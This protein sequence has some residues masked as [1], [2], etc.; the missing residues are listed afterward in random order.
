[1]NMLRA[2][3][4]AIAAALPM[5]PVWGSSFSTISQFFDASQRY[6]G[7]VYQYDG[8][9]R[10]YDVT[11]QWEAG[12]SSS[13]YIYDYRDQPLEGIKQPYN[14]GAWWMM[15]LNDGTSLAADGADFSGIADCA[16]YACAV[17]GQGSGT[18][19]AYDPYLFVGTDLIT[20]DARGGTDPDF[21]NIYNEGVESFGSAWASGIV[22]YT[23]GPVPEPT[24]WAMMVGGFGLVGGAMRVRRKAAVSFA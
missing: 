11:I 13:F 2:S 23:L 17:G 3:I 22:T 24:S 4:Y 21:S 10:I 14:G 16:W 18:T 9:L 19:K 12:A 8:P 1:M 6:Q 7:W 5:T 20:V 15:S